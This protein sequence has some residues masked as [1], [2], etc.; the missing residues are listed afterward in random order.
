MSMGR[1]HSLQTVS[2]LSFRDIKGLQY[3]RFQC[4]ECQEC[5]QRQDCI[6]DRKGHKTLMVRKSNLSSSHVRLFF[7]SGKEAAETWQNPLTRAMRI[8]L[9]DR[10]AKKVYNLRGQVVEAV[11]GIITDARNGWQFLRGG[12]EKVQVDWKIRCVAHNIGKVIGFTR[13]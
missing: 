1:R 7:R 11:N 2:Q 12:L 10:A 5:P 4:K 13:S 3:A 8:K 9:K 6:G